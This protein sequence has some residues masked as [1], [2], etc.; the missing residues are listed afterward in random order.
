MDDLQ[1][2]TYTWMHGLSKPVKGFLIAGD[3]NV[4]LPSELQPLT[5]E[6]VAARVRDPHPSRARAAVGWLASL[7]VWACNTFWSCLHGELAQ[8]LYTWR[9][10]Q[11]NTTQID[12]ICIP[13]GWNAE[14]V[15]KRGWVAQGKDS[16]H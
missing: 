13:S 14:L 12:Y 5:G 15:M 2:V 4:T 7:H 1:G 3:L 10:S 8:Q 11:N 9:D 6:A 16:D